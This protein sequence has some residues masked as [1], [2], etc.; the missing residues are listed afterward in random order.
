MKKLKL[1]GYPMKVH[2]N[3]AFI[4]DMFTS[5]LEVAKFEGAAIRTVSG[6]R[7]Q[8]KKAIR[9]PDG[10]FRATFED[11]LLL[12]DIVFLR[13]WYAVQPRQFYTPITNILEDDPTRMRLNVELRALKQQPVPFKRDALYRDIEERPM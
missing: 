11:K 7:G 4:K 12:S 9:A 6:I 8:L 10:A 13:T 5:S 2:R 1:I 3:T